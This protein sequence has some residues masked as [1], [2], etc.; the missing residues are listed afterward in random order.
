PAAK[1]ATPPPVPERVSRPEPAAKGGNR[2][3]VYLGLVAATA[4]G[5]YFMLRGSPSEA[6]SNEPEQ[7]VVNAPEPAAPAEEEATPTEESAPAAE[8]TSA[9]TEEAETPESEATDESEP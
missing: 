2:G 3:L 5:L 7:T 8:P 4:A 1:V 6:P 9:E